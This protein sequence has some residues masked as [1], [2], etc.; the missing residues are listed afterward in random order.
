LIRVGIIGCGRI[1]DQHAIEI[2]KITGCEIVGVC[3]TEELMAKQMSERFSVKEYVTDVHTLLEEAKPDIVH[4]TTPPQSHFALGKICL[5]AGCSVLMEKPFTLNTREAQELIKIAGE[6]NQK[7]TVGHNAQ[8]SHAAKRMRELVRRGDLGGD[9]VHMESIWCYSFH[10]PGYAKAILG[11]R[12]HWI[13]SLPGRYLHDILSHGISRIVEF[14]KTDNPTVIA[15]GFVSPILKSIKENDIIDELRVII[16]DNNNTTAYFTFSSQITPPIKQ[17]RIHGPKN[18]LVVDHEHQTVLKINNNYKYYL[19]HFIPP[20]IDAK[21]NIANSM[22]N[23]K[24]FLKRDFHFESGRR[25]LI[26]SFYRSVSNGTPLPIP[27]TQIILT[28]K[29]M[30]TIFEQI[31]T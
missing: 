12:S 8:F 14:L 21:Q 28:T 23:I 6:K 3:D 2:K 7:I 9:P 29:I 26:E 24:K 31:Y 15:S 13:R 5:E 20:L 1:A 19:N 18:S 27:Y 4:I 16:Y 11:D 17:F 25:F 22:T 30:D 10:N